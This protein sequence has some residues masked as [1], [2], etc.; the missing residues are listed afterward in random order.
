MV[1]RPVFIVRTQAG[2]LRL[3]PDEWVSTHAANVSMNLAA[4]RPDRLIGRPAVRIEEV[5]VVKR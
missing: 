3:P 4:E 5:R 1:Y 2:D